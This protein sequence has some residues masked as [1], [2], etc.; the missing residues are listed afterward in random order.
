MEVWLPENGTWNGRTMNT[1]NGGVNGCVHYIDMQY[2]SSLGF[3][4][5]GDNAGHNSSSFDGSWFAGSRE[6]ILDWVYR[7]RHSA[8]VTG[9]EVVNQFYQQAPAFS[10]YIGCSAGGA[11]GMKSAQEY[12][13]D[14]DGIIAGSAAA[15]FN[16]LQAWSGR[17]VQLTG[18]SASDNRFLT[19][20]NWVTVQTAILDQC[21]AKIDGVN[22]GILEDPTQCQ[23]DSSVLACSNNATLAGC[24]TDSQVQTVG[25]VFSELYNTEGE[26][27]FPALLYGS[28]VDAF[29][30]GQLSGSVQ[31]ISSDWYKYAI[32]NDPNWNALD[33][34]QADY[35]RADDLDATYGNVSSYSGD[36]SGFR[37]AGGKLITYHGMA[38][39]LVSAG[40][41]QRYYLKV[42]RTMGLDNVGLDEFYRYFRISGMAHCGVG[43]ISGA[44]AWMFGQ[45]LA[46][47]IAPNNIIDDLQRWVENGTAPETITGTKFW[48]D[49]QASGIQ[50]QRPHCR[51]PYRTTFA[52]GDSAQA[53]AWT[54]ELIEGWRECGPGVS[55]RLCNSDGSFV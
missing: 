55:P 23:F 21:D 44:G 43:G 20:A 31:G 3:A 42:A 33:M 2:V 17:F 11:Q 37:A 40:N 28:Q 12:P 16:H 8:V 54:C 39:P 47:R 53:S 29:R 45:S 36:L 26:L 10:Y 22:D 38:D 6:V 4:A 51:F 34:D 18:T 25:N 32:L 48:Y 49:Q 1:D 9:K 19:S 27:L 13:D 52:G 5:I 14:F 41:S 30:L 50:F 35:A 15:D 24:L 7:A 46:S